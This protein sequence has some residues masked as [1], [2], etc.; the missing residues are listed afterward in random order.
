[1]QLIFHSQKYLFNVYDTFFSN[2]N[3]TFLKLWFTQ[4]KVKMTKLGPT[5][6]IVGFVIG[7]IFILL[8]TVYKHPIPD[9]EITL[10]IGATDSNVLKF[11]V[12][13]DKADVQDH[14]LVVDV[15]KDSKSA[16][17]GADYHIIKKI[18]SKKSYSYS[19]SKP[20]DIN[21]KITNIG[22]EPIKTVK[23]SFS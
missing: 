12:T 9:P 8:L 19:V 15:K 22:G 17:N 13:W 10:N 3:D 18:K 20:F 6:E 14:I 16:I 7:V 1:M 4:S 5:Q 23:R 2:V 21:V 11:N